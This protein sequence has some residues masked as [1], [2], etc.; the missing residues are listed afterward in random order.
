MLKILFLPLFFLTREILVPNFRRE[1]SDR[2][3][4]REG[5]IFPCYPSYHDATDDDN[6]DDDVVE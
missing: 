4:F 3:K 2:L 1:S 6:D 5:G